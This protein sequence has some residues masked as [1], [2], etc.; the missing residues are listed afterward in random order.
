MFTKVKAKT[1]ISIISKTTDKISLE[2]PESSSNDAEVNV[3]V[4]K[5]GKKKHK[6]KKHKHH[7]EDEVASSKKSKKSK[8]LVGAMPPNVQAALDNIPPE[9]LDRKD[10]KEKKK[11]KKHKGYRETLFVD[12]EKRIKL[13]KF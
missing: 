10:T 11:K 12:E 4:E 13:V 9:E 8:K 5:E 2:R 6:S 3:L 1:F 7:K